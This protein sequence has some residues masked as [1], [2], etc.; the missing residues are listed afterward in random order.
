MS[1][2]AGAEPRRPARLLVAPG[3]DPGAL[4]REQQARLVAIRKEP[5]AVDVRVVEVHLDALKAPA[6]TLDLFGRSF[7]GWKQHTEKFDRSGRSYSWRGMLTCAEDFVSLQV[8]GNRVY[9]TVRTK[10]L[11][12][13]IEPLDERIHAVIEIKA[14]PSKEH[15][16]EFPTGAQREPDARDDRP[17]PQEP[18]QK[19][20]FTQAEQQ[21]P[22]P[23]GLFTTVHV[24]A[25]RFSVA[26]QGRLAAIEA[27]KS[28]K[29]V[30]LLELN[31]RAL[32]PD[33]KAL[34]LN[35]ASDRSFIAMR[36]EVLGPLKPGQRYTWLGALVLEPG[37]TVQFIVNDDM[38]TGSLRYDGEFFELRPLSGAAHALI[39]IETAKFPGEHPPKFPSGAQD[40]GEEP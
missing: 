36:T 26:M 7:T 17:P 38:C 40:E 1:E 33:R 13:E 6:V 31:A 28:T 27:R 24:R 20:L 9:G 29:R 11:H 3:A 23:P 22:A 25:D 19:P 2:P 14:L 16:P 15:P 18:K 8:D 10:E 37:N 12:L 32:T 5:T 34:R 21:R 35:L 30:H 4:S 39:R